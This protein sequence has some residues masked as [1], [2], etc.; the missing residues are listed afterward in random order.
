MQFN[1]VLTYSHDS[2]LL[3]VLRERADLT[4]VTRSYLQDYLLRYPEQRAQMLVSDRV[5]QVYRHQA[6]LRPNAPISV[7]NLRRVLLQLRDGGELSALYRRYDLT[8]SRK[9][10]RP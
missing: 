7:E 6:L 2:N 9:V 10:V 5:D 1:A 8:Q 3:M 4:V